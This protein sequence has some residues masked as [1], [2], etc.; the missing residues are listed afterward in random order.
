[1]WNWVRYS[2]FPPVHQGHQEL[3]WAGKFGRSA[4][5]T[6]MRAGIE[7]IQ[8]SSKRVWPNTGQA[9]EV[10]RAKSRDVSIKHTIV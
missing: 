6:P 1:M 7:S 3:V 5:V 8:H 2:R 10:I 4:K 9:F